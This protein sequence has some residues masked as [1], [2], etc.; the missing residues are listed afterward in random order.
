MGN[1]GGRGANIRFVSEGFVNVTDLRP[2]GPSAI[3]I[4][5][6]LSPPFPPCSSLFQS[7]S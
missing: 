7:L 1:F 5:E 6:L 2:F 4:G 3:M